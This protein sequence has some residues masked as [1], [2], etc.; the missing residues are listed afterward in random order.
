MFYYNDPAFFLLIALMLLASVAS[1][2]VKSTFKKYHNVRN[3]RGLT[4]AQAAE[5]MLRNNGIYD[6]QIERIGGFLTDHYDPRANTIRLSAP[7]YDNPSVASVSVACHEAGHALQHAKGY[8][9]LKIRTA[10]LP[11]AQ[12]GSKSLMP[13]L[14]AGILFS[15]PALVQVGIVFFAFAVFFQL[16]TLPVE[17]NASARALANMNENGILVESEN[18][19]AKKVL[20]AAAMTYVAA[21]AIAVVQLVRLIL[22]NNRRD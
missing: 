2:R 6:V 7:V 12:L 5:Q 13:L 18:D 15:I 20:T 14:L 21:A 16:A 10:I 3:M 1:A 4:G 8:G 22:L 11:L 19:D 17:F 9:P